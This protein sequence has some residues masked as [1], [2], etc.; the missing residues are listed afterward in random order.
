[1]PGPDSNLV[2]GTLPQ[3]TEAVSAGVGRGRHTIVA[4]T[5]S[6]SASVCSNLRRGRRC[7]QITVTAAIDSVMDDPMILESRL[8]YPETL[9]KSVMAA[10]A[11]EMQKERPESAVDENGIDAASGHKDVTE[12]GAME[13]TAVDQCHSAGH[14]ATRK[15]R[16]IS[17]SQHAQ[18]PGPVTVTNLQR[19]RQ[20]IQ[21]QN[22][23]CDD[24][25]STEFATRGINEEAKGKAEGPKR[26]RGD[27]AG[28]V[29]WV[30]NGKTRGEKRRKKRSPNW[31]DEETQKLAKGK[32]EFDERNGNKAS[33]KVIKKNVRG[34]TED[35]CRM[36]WDTLIKTYKA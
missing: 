2:V 4:S 28:E 27:P 14:D 31:T 18:K 1:M 5:S 10:R 19:R 34:R 16:G 32:I 12:R 24:D 11:R 6:R 8:P 30:A 35:E 33:W 17:K 23:G 29:D 9:D 13:A 15:L 26:R 22:E 7:I 21:V 3:R 36:R 20:V 25:S